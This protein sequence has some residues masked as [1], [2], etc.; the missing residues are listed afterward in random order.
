M[1]SYTGIITSRNAY[2]S[3]KLEAIALGIIY[4]NNLVSYET[5]LLANIVCK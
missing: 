4:Q 3:S 2:Q 1:H 5:F